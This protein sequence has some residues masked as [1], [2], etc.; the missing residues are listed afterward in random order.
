[1]AFEDNGTVMPVQPMNNGNGGF[2][3]DGGFGTLL[4]LF[5]VFGMLGGWGNGFG[6]GY[7]GN[8]I[9]PW[10]NQS[11]QI[12]NGFQNQM[13][14]S[15]VN[16]IQNAVTS[17]FGDVQTALCGGFA[18]VTASVTGAQNALAQQ[19]YTNQITDLERSFA[20][21]TANTQGL[22]ALQ[23]QLAQCC[24]D[25]RLATCQT[26]NIVQ[27]EGAATRS[28]IQASV[29]TVLDKMCQ[30]KIDEKNEKIAELQNRLNMADFAAS[31]A[32]QNNYLQNALTAQ[33]QYFLSLYPPAAAAAATHTATANG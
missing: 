30:D 23:S 15:S 19:L 27:N 8:D 12:S 26:Q 32:S 25:N 31:Q 13:L 33:T 21:Q 9:Y 18:N 20:A 3:F 5:L 1:M 28:A 29:Q 17:G 7:G 4:I 10:M 11:N 14:G 16:G 24:C 22:S 6:G 2:G